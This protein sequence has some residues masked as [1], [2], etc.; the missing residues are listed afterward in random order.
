MS[1]KIIIFLVFALLSA[2]NLG[3]VRINLGHSED[4]SH[5][6]LSLFRSETCP[7]EF[8]SLALINHHLSGIKELNRIIVAASLN[9]LLTIFF[10]AA[11]LLTGESPPLF[12]SSCNRARQPVFFKFIPKIQQYL[13]WIGL[14]NKKSIAPAYIWAR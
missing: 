10:F 6:P 7:T 4:L 5:C 2:G 12:L 14:H 11:V 3:L 8:N 1:N 9:I 13:F